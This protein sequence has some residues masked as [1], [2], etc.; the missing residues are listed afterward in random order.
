MKRIGAESCFVGAGRGWRLLRRVAVRSGV[1]FTM[2]VRA[3]VL[4][5]VADDRLAAWTRCR[6]Q[7]TRI[8][9]FPT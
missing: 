6:V 7:E 8:L 5:S 2:I 3:R 9:L 1:P 4:G